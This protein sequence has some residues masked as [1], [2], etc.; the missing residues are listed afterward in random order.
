[1]G[2]YDV[3]LL[4]SL[5]LNPYERTEQRKAYRNGYYLVPIHI[6]KAYKNLVYKL[7][8]LPNVEYLSE[9]TFA[10]PIFAELSRKEKEYIVE[11]LKKFGE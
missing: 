1:M 4:N 3:S 9:R 11:N 2:F 7:G 6:Q 5:M 8:D 10:I